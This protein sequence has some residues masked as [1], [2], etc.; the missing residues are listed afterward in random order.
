ML[1]KSRPWLG[2]SDANFLSKAEF[3]DEQDAD[4]SGSAGKET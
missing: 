1:H 4:M 2:H 3:C